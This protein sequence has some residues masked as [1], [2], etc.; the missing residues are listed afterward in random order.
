LTKDFG[1]HAELAEKHLT[2]MGVKKLVGLVKESEAVKM[3]VWT[4]EEKGE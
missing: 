2:T 4:N 3:H 1:K